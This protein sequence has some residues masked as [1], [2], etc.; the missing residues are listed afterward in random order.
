MRLG[1]FLKKSSTDKMPHDLEVKMKTTVTKHYVKFF[2]PGSFMSDTSVK[3]TETRDPDKIEWLDRA[4]CA[5]FFSRTEIEIDGETLV[6]ERRD[7]SNRF[8]L[9]G[10]VKMIHDVRTESPGSILLQNMESNGWDRVIECAQGTTNMWDDDVVL[11]T[12]SG[13]EPEKF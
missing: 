10:T 6:G 8:F 5:R 3:P 4:Y 9:G 11:P 2:L 7:V 13:R 1:I 12:N